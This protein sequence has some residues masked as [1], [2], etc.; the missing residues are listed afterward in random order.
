MEFLRT[1]QEFNRECQ[2]LEQ[3]YSELAWDA[4]KIQSMDVLSKKKTAFNVMDQNATD[5]TSQISIYHKYVSTPINNT[6]QS[7]KHAITN[8]NH[9]KG[10]CW[11]N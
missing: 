4:I 9:K 11:I 3:Y 2:A 10:Q 8:G 7:L 1:D 6:T 5:A